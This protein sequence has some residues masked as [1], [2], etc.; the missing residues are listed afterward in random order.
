MGDGNGLESETEKCVGM[1]NF[2]VNCKSDFVL[3]R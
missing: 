3:K 2:S 1:Q